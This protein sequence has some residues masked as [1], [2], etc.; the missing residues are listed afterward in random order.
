[1]KHVATS[2]IAATTSD[3]AT[4]LGQLTLGVT[5]AQIALK[6]NL[7]IPQTAAIAHATLKHLAEIL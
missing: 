1:M 5:T 6:D 4:V 2:S 3:A 7:A